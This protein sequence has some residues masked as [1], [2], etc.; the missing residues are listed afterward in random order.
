MWKSGPALAC[1]NTIALQAGIAW[2]NDCN[3]TQPEIPFGGYKESALGRENGR[4]AI[5]SGHRKI[6]AWT[7]IASFD[8]KP[9]LTKRELA[10]QIV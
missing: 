9:G 2:I 5:D 3:V 10:D 8:K 6:V 7:S 1:G 4:E